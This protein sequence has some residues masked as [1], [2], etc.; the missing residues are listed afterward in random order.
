M[1]MMNIGMAKAVVPEASVMMMPRLKVSLTTPLSWAA[2]PRNANLLIVAQLALCQQQP[3][4]LYV[5]WDM[6][7][8]GTYSKEN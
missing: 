2:A 3:P 4:Q 8:D 6:P 5:S 1:S 7:L